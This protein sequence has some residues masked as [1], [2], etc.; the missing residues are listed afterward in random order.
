MDPAFMMAKQTPSDIWV[1]TYAKRRSTR[2][3]ACSAG[4]SAC[5]DDGSGAPELFER[6]SPTACQCVRTKNAFIV[7]AEGAYYTFRH[8]IKLDVPVGA[9]FN[10]QVP[11]HIVADVLNPATGKL[12]TG[13]DC[14][15]DG[16]CENVPVGVMVEAGNAIQ[17]PVEKLFEWTGIGDLDSGDPVVKDQYPLHTGTPSYRITGVNFDL[18][19][20]Y[21]GSLT[22]TQYPWLA[23]FLDSQP[24]IA[25]LKISAQGGWHSQGGMGHGDNEHFMRGAAHANFTV[26]PETFSVYPRGVHIRVTFG[27]SVGRLVPTHLMTQFASLVIYSG[28]AALIVHWL[29][30]RCQGYASWVYRASKREVIT[31]DQVHQKN[32]AQA[33]IAATAFA[34]IK[35]I[36]DQRQSSSGTGGAYFRQSVVDELKEAGM[37]DAEARAVAHTVA[38]YGALEFNK[39]V[40]RSSYQSKVTV[41]KMSEHVFKKEGKKMGAQSAPALK[42]TV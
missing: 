41:A 20:V 6:L 8:Q 15:H 31:V 35:K 21:T 30:L 1:Y 34:T 22:S 9:D 33:I 32:A 24:P 17:I 26:E 40:D 19:V 18:R 37:D 14:P 39:F 12:A 36:A 42:A 28:L 13:A 5:F 23:P 2:E 11:T 27:G 10:P 16:G 38:S 25:T 29:V 7:G 4:A 3:V